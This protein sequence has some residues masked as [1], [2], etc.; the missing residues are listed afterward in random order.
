[1]LYGYKIFKDY[2]NERKDTFTEK[3]ITSYNDFEKSY[4]HELKKI[5]KDKIENIAYIFTKNN[6]NLD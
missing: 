6:N 2:I 5:I 1:M 3:M 4:V